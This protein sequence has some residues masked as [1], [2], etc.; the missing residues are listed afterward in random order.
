M[1]SK[2]PK[3]EN[4]A[5]TEIVK[6]AQ[7]SGKTIVLPEGNDDRI[8]EAAEKVSLLNIC[9]LILIGNKI[10]LKDKLSKKAM[11]NIEIIDVE[12][13]GKKRE[14]YAKSLYDLR[15]SKGL[16]E[17]QAQELVKN[18]MYY[19][20][21]MVKSED[22]DG[23]V[24][25]A[26]TESAD[27][28]RPAFQIIK[29]RE[30]ISKVSSSLILETPKGSSLGENGLIVMG[31]CAVVVNPT[32]KELAEIAVLSAK[33]AEQIC[34][35]KP[36][37]ALLSYST[38]ANVNVENEDV[39]KI[40]RAYKLARRMD[41]MLIIDGEIQADAAIVPEVAKRKCLDSSLEGRANVLVFPD[42]EA[43]NIGYK[44]VQRFANV[45][46][47]GPLLQGL[48]K[49]INDLSRGANADEIVLVIA[50]TALQAKN[51]IKGE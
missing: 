44:L 25:G 23:V 45:K 51:S 20:T 13:E 2:K 28:M 4:D 10:L 50:I 43:G 29:T 8:I 36:R 42:L 48:K 31:D 26:V 39:Q 27:V 6:R 37:V 16:T 1:F 18:P 21:M 11:K 5:F 22:A 34:G 47:V 41:S 38:K 15:K 17:E 3:V 46:A 30:G 19:A 32:D 9:K 49:P 7:G 35:I 24:A 12:S 33:T 40:K 14:M